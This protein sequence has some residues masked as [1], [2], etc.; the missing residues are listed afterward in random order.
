MLG[1]GMGMNVI[2]QIGRGL[3]GAAAV[4][5]ALNPLPLVLVA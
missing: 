4:R 2:A 5:L 3:I 1:V